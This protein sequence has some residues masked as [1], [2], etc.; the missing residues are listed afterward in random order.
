MSST[1]LMKK[2]CYAILWIPTV[3]HIPIPFE[4]PLNG[5]VRCDNISDIPEE[6]FNIKV[7]ARER[8]I[9]IYVQDEVD[10]ECFIPFI[11][12]KYEDFSHNGMVKYSYDA[13]F[14]SEDGF[15]FDDK[16]FPAA[17]YHLIKSFYHTHE[18]HED[19]TDSSLVPYL[20]REDVN[21]H[22]DDNPALRE[23]LRNHE[24]TV[25]NLVK[26]GQQ[27]LREVLD[28][29]K[30]KGITLALPD[31]D[32]FSKLFVMARGYN[33]YFHSLCGS[34][35]NRSCNTSNC[36]EKEMRRRAFNIKN[37]VRYFDVMNVFFDVRFRK[38]TYKEMISKAEKSIDISLQNLKKTGKSA[39]E[40]TVWAIVG[41]IISLAFGLGSIWYSI[42]QSRHS[43]EELNQIKTELVRTLQNTNKK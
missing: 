20:S 3:S 1:C 21:I 40:A 32:S 22:E 37:S 34:V 10:S 18:F 25:I 17:V 2:K 5:N 29:E 6:P 38:S 19:E 39:K 11:T 13:K 16:E 27:Y 35:Y 8:D 43:S 28:K 24:E 14:L 4:K 26:G 23:Y 30:N 33:V 7:V 41:I 12:L 31:Y 15:G 36:R 42:V 9:E